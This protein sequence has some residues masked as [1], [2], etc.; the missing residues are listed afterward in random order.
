[1]VFESQRPQRNRR[2]EIY[3]KVGW[4][5]EVSVPVPVSVQ[6]K[7]VEESM[8]LGKGFIQIK[9]NGNRV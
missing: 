5:K 1:M 9:R 3:R 8:D 2:T 6:K 4:E 7:S